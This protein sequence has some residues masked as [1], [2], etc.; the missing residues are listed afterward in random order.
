MMS[1]NCH[2]K[3]AAFRRLCVETPSSVRRGCW[4]IPAAF[5]RLCV[6]TNR[7]K[8]SRKILF[9]AAF[10]RLCVE[11]NYKLYIDCE[12][13]PAAF[14]RLCVETLSINRSG[15]TWQTQPPSGGCVL[16]LYLLI[17]QFCLI[18]QPPSGG[19]VLKLYRAEQL[20]REGE[21]AAFRRL[22]VETY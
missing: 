5:R 16:K 21:P 11:T 14:R 12:R 13:F 20:E 6:E 10:R 7:C 3:P 17:W 18:F 19:C 22:C 15:K 1:Q 4:S 2:T 9:P 8:R